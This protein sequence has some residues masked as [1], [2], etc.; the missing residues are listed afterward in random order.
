MQTA[1]RI[2]A[3]DIIR[4]VALLGIL[5]VN[6]GLFSFPALYLDPVTSWP[7]WSDQLVLQLIRFFGE[8]KFISMFSFLFGL[9]F[10]IFIQRAAAKTNHPARLF[11]RRLLILLGI[12]LIHAHFIW[13]GDVLCIYSIAGIM[14]LFFRNSRPQ[15]VL[16]WA[17]SLLLVPIIL[18]LIG[19]W[20]SGPALLAG[21]APDIASD[22][23]IGKLAQ[24]TYS[25]GTF[26]EI[27][28]QNRHDVWVTR[29]GYTLI[30]PQIF[31]MFL[32]GTYAG[33]RQLFQD[34]QPHLGWIKRLAIWA[35][36]VGVIATVAEFAY[37]A[38]PQDSLA[39]TLSQ[40]IGNYVGG[41]AFGIFYIC[42]V[43]LI[44]QLARGRKILTPLAA[45]GQMAATNYIMQSVVCVFIFYSFGLGRYGHISPVTGLG[46]TM[47]IYMMQIG[48]SNWWM[49]RFSNGPVEWMW[50]TLT[51][52]KVMPLKR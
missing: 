1:N 24:V 35:L 12:G 22:T 32:L 19:Y 45:V 23:A 43:A 10:T 39:Y 8:G 18:L 9:G 51:Y 6:M 49:A 5:I 42:A 16:I 38:T 28:M 41:P 2:T 36:L 30:I 4:G 31:A 40:L 37:V 13:Y 14:L 15:T 27:F 29:I 50:R 17:L 20:L 21:S 11:A 48:F 52:G 47:A 26:Y 46:I 25:S 34:I 44:L 33:K 7:A 3:L